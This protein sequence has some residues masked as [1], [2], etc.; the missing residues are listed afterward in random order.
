VPFF[1]RLLAAEVLPNVT[2][3]KQFPLKEN[4]LEK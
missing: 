3:Q 1:S 2:D 4:D